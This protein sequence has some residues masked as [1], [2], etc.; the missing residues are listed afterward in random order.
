MYTCPIVILAHDL[1]WEYAVHTLIVDTRVFV[2]RI[3][4]LA[5]EIAQSYSLVLLKV[6]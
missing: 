5:I 3:F 1:L 6:S 4:V 2:D